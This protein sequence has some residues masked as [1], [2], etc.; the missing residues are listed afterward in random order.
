MKETD[1]S[2][3][4]ACG[5]NCETCQYFQ[6]GNCRG[7]NAT[8]GERVWEGRKSICEIVSCCQKHKVPYCGA[9][10]EFP[11]EWIINRISEWDKNGIQ[12]LKDLRKEMEERKLKYN[13]IT[14]EWEG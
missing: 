8:G 10:T 1:F 4:T 7:C 2:K 9:C 11:C 13:D 12:H 3:V 14:R 6:K 5:G